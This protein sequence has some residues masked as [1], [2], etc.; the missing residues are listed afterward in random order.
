MGDA[1]VP[2]ARQMPRGGLLT[3]EVPDCLVGAWKLIRQKAAA[4]HLRKDAG[5]SPALPRGRTNLLRHGAEIQDVYDEEI[6][7]LGALD[8]DRAAE[9]VAPIK[10]DIA[11]IVGRIVVADLAIRP[12]PAL[13]PELVAGLHL[14]RDRDVRMPA[15]V[16]GNILVEHRLRLIYTKGN[17]RHDAPQSERPAIHFLILLLRVLK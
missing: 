4:I 1:C 12:F 9:D 7:G 14:S 10:A 11:N 3:M 5:I 8:A 2:D 13:H 16:A 17:L 15:I 6:P